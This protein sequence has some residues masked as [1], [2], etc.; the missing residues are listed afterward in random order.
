MS[1]DP[2]PLRRAGIIAVGSELLTPFRTDTNSLWLTSRLNDVGIEVAVKHVV[3]DRRD[4]LL[5]VLG[6]TLALVEVVIL[7]GGLGPTADDLTRDV[8]AE[9]FGLPLVQDEAVVDRIRARFAARGL[10]MPEIN[11]RQ[12]LVPRGARVLPNDRGTAPGLLIERDRGWVILLPGPPHEMAPIFDTVIDDVLVP[13]AG[14][15]RLL[16]RVVR[17]TGLTESQVDEAAQPVYARWLEEA[18]RVETSIL[19]QP[20]QIELHLSARGGDTADAAAALARAVD[21]LVAVLGPNVFSTDDRSLEQV[22][23]EHLRSRG[24]RLAAAESCTGG[25]LTKR[26]TDVAGSSDYVDRSVVCYSNRAKVEVVGVAEALI[27]AHGAVSE[28]VGAA[29]AREVRE[30]AGVEVGVGITGIAG[31][32]GGTGAKPVGTVVVAVAHPG[33]EVVR[34]FRFLGGRSQVR[35]QAS[36]AALDTVRRLLEAEGDA[37]VHRR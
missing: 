8:V 30:R 29:M 9:A 31:P 1:S 6:S 13:C 37:P 35:F 26:L 11:R 25:L 22:V 36:Q 33:G 32:G 4:D 10:A 15:A 34:T 14:V 17:I 16:R 21:Q 20:G 7:T 5:A 23:G 24:W 28:P 12:A 19:A 3:G 2:Q 18:P 27:A